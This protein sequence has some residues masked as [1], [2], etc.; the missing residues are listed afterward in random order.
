MKRLDGLVMG[1]SCTKQDPSGRHIN[2]NC[3]NDAVQA[4][5]Q[6]LELRAVTKQMQID[7]DACS[8]NSAQES[9]DISPPK[10]RS[11]ARKPDQI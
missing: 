6:I 7:G 3:P 9:R 4:I 11:K 10:N 2:V 1:D 5:L 8:T